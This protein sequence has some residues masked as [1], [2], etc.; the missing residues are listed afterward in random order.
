MIN[1]KFFRIHTDDNAYL[2]K[3]PRGLFTTIGKLVDNNTLDDDEV[4]L[5]WENRHWFEDHLP[6]P[7]FYGDGNSIKA[8][9]WF[10][11]SEK[12]LEMFNKM[13][14]YFEMSKKYN[15]RLYLTQTDEIPGDIIYEDDFQVG[16]S[17]SSH[18]G[19]G[20]ITT[21]YHE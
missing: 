6:V 18:K 7:P 10:K 4:T 19:H 9:T 20:Y 13:T 15:I 5:Y 8:I 21:L 16:V 11:S 2:T 12:G 17:D 14:F 1:K 3:L